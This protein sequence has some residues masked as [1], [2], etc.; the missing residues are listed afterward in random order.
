MVLATCFP[1]KYPW[2]HWGGGRQRKSQ[3]SR[4][5]WVQVVSCG[6]HWVHPIQWNLNSTNV[7]TKPCWWTQQGGKHQICVYQSLER[8]VLRDIFPP[9]A[10][11]LWDFPAVSVHPT[12]P[13][14][15]HFCCNIAPTTH[16]HSKLRHRTPHILAL[17]G[18][19]LRPSKALKTEIIMAGCLYSGF[20]TDPSIY[21]C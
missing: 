6:G 17:A 1:F 18:C 7:G 12:V 11:R 16:L 14:G 21:I 2:E 5:T 13:P 19:H 20:K 3:V 10:P 15:S 4:W 8:E 9:V